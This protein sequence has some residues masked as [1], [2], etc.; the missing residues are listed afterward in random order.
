MTQSNFEWQAFI[1]CHHLTKFGGQGYCSS[2]D[3]I[4]LVCHVIKQV[5][6]IKGS[7][8]Y[9]DRSLSRQA[10]ILQSLVIIGTVVVEMQK[11]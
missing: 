7:G 2:R 10:T 4:F 1:V 3:I 5:H 8:N 6:V 9:N 11:L